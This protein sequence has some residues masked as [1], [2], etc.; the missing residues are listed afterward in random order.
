MSAIHRMLTDDPD[1]SV[2]VMA[3]PDAVCGAC[4]HR[5]VS[6]CVLNGGESEQEMVS[7]DLAVLQRLGLKLGERL[8][9]RE[10][11]TRIGTAVT[12][13]DLPT[14]CGRCR[15]LPL[16]YCREGITRLNDAATN[17]TPSAQPPATGG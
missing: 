15:W 3:A 6:G 1:V 5:A 13:N 16:G 9:W 12:G 11:L 7:Q 8:R 14:I 2:E 17:S 4:P 10:I